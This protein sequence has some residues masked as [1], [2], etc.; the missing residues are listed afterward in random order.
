MVTETVRF[1]I[2][3][4]IYSTSDEDGS[5]ILDIEHDKIY[6][7]I[8]IG[9]LIW[10]K[11]AG[12]SRGLMFHSIVDD[13]SQRFQDVSRQTIEADVSRLLDS[14]RG[15]GI[16][17]AGGKSGYLRSSLS[18]SI[19][20]RLIGLARGST[21]VLFRLRLYTLS[22][23]L[24][25]ATVNLMLRFLGFHSLCELVRCWPVRAGDTKS[26]AK[27][28]VCEAVRKAASWYPRESMC[29]QRSAI[30][31]CLLRQSGIAADMV[32]GCR[33]IPFGAHAW[34]EVDGEVANDKKQ[35]Q[36]FYKVLSRL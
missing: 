25:I 29:L 30:T 26:D 18:P 14:F 34:V 17:V 3:P 15:K 10:A 11:L 9:S 35:V 8:G 24:G 21:S 2:S 7:L 23:F 27:E 5:T 20:L 12:S 28:Q 33:K 31:T 16:I 6:S 1:T 32:I 13:L 4:N 19:N 22:A 36:Q